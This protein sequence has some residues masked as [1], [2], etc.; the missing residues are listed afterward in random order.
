[1]SRRC[2]LRRATCSRT[3]CA[4]QVRALENWHAICAHNA[5]ET[6]FGR[7]ILKV[8]WIDLLSWWPTQTIHVVLTAV[9][10]DGSELSYKAHCLLHNATNRDYHW[11]CCRALAPS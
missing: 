11:P 3:C 2:R 8:S 1:M 7:S 6:F 5:A 10:S 4:L 9:L